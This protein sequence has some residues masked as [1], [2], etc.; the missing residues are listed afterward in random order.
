MIDVDSDVDD[1]DMASVEPGVVPLQSLGVIDVGATDVGENELLS[2]AL[3]NASVRKRDDEFLVKRS[4][5]FVNEYARKNADGSLSCGDINDPNHMMG[6]FPTLWPYGR[7]GIETSRPIVVPYD[8]HVQYALQYCDKRFRTDLNFVFQAFGVLQKRQ[9]CRSACLQ[10]T[11]SAFL[12]HQKEFRELTAQDLMVASEEESKKVP[13]SNPTVRAFRNQLSALRTKVTGTDESRIKI[14]GQIKGMTTM[15]G[16]PSLWITINPSDTGDPIAQVFCGEEID[17]D[18][19]VRTA[20][21]NSEQRTQNIAADPYAAAKFFH[22]VVNVLIEELFGI[23]GYRQSGPVKRTEGIFG[24]VAAYIGTVEAQGRGTLHLHIVLWLCGSPTSS[25]MKE[26]LKS[27]NFRSRVTSFIKANIRADLDGA[28]GSMVRQMPTTK[29]VSYSRPCDPRMEN[30]SQN[31]HNAELA[32]AKAVQ[33]H[34]CSP[35]AC[36]VVK[37]GRLQCKRR[38]PFPTSSEDFIREDG[39]WGPKRSFAYINSWIPAIMQCV[40][41]NQDIKLIS[42]GGETRDIGFYIS[43]YVAKRQGHSSNTSALLAK[44][45]AFHKTK[46]RYNSDIVDLNKKLLQRCANTLSREQEFSAPEAISYL[47]TWGDRFISHFFVD[48]FWS[49]VQSMIKKIFPSVQ[50]KR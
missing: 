34:Q 32:L 36:L 30:Y 2:H 8:V 26:A 45:L 1:D 18:N 37:Q 47:M 40:R 27:E 10:V 41:A 21:P 46:E 43:K 6:A 33:F 20:G 3:L 38:A 13:F 14:R 19:F 11:K 22:F 5:E 35:Q 44:K 28:D 7:G 25:R 9:V 50:T 24:Q 42:N 16:P 39:T 17:V 15:K 23:R 4:S 49:R 48:I 31:A 12:Q 29:S